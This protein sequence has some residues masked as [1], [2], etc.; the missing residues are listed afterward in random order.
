M[1]T[2]TVD[3]PIAPTKV[4]ALFKKLMVAYDFSPCAGMALKLCA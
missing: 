1:A 4:T 2:L 3:M